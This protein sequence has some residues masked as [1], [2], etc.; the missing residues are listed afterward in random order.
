MEITSKMYE[1]RQKRKSNE[2]IPKSRV[3]WKRT[4]VDSISHILDSDESTSTS[5]EEEQV[6][7]SSVS[8]V[9]NEEQLGLSGGTADDGEDNI[10][11]PRHKRRSMTIESSDSSSDSDEPGVRTLVRR[12]RAIDDDDDDPLNKENNGEPSG[13]VKAPNKKQL[14]KDNLKQLVEKRRSKNPRNSWESDEASSSSV[15]SP[16]TPET[17]GEDED[18]QEMK[19]FIE[20]DEEE[21]PEDEDGNRP[22]RY[23]ELFLKHRI[24][25]FASNDLYTH[26]QKVIKALLINIAD[27]TFLETL[28]EGKREKRYAKDM[29]KSL[30]YLD[31]RI[32]APRLEK[33]TT[34]CRWKPRYKERVNAYPKLNIS[35]MIAVKQ[36]CDACELLRY[37]TYFVALSGQAYDSETLEN[38]DFLPEDK[39]LLVVGKTCGRRT[40]VY[41]RV[42]HYKFHLYQSCIPFLQKS[43][44]HSVKESVEIALSKMEEQQFITEAVDR[45]QNY[46]DA[47]ET[48][49]DETEESLIA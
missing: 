19:D 12:R 38:D 29:L 2:T 45:L 30:N 41:H 37:C 42:R 33:L 39:Q 26:L 47:A 40:E 5:E 49:K 6:D 4:K 20:Q 7:S 18:S 3:D 21:D 28:Y 9:E 17:L 35:I 23:Q 15:Y 36:S 43:K 1:T 31:E 14:R 34:S 13:E 27:N 46:V 22:S 24:P 11:K 8:S 25:Q 44:K 48:F 10:R 32:I 16:L